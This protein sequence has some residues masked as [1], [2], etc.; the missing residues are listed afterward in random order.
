[1]EVICQ[2]QTTRTRVP[3]EW[4]KC[5]QME[6]YDCNEI[7]SMN[8]SIL[9]DWLHT[10][11]KSNGGVFGHSWRIKIPTCWNYN[12]M[13][14]TKEMQAFFLADPTHTQQLLPLD[15]LEYRSKSTYATYYQLIRVVGMLLGRLFPQYGLGFVSASASFY[16]TARGWVLPAVLPLRYYDTVTTMTATIICLMTS[17]EGLAF[18]ILSQR[19]QQHVPPRG[20]AS[21][22][23]NHTN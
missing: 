7:P 5:T 11:R 19:S 22:P 13:D 15:L 14:I 12:T 10:L 6:L 17:L 20:P 3:T 8:E 9:D 21:L 18:E 1:M 2:K 4:P 23:C 16:R